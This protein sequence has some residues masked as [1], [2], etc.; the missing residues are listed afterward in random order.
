MYSSVPKEIADLK[1]KKDAK[2]NV[3]INYCGSWGYYGMVRMASE[4]ITGLYPSAKI[5]EARIPGGTGTFDVIVKNT[6]GEEEYVFSK[7][8]GDGRLN[9]TNLPSMVKKLQEHVEK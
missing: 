7:N 9:Y 2:F 1:T 5:N 3:Q 6:K 8:N 4:T